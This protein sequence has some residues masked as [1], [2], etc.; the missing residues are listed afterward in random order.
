MRYSPFNYMVF[1]FGALLCAPIIAHAGTWTVNVE[2][3]RIANTDRHYS[4]G[5]RLG[6]VSDAEDGSDIPILRDTLQLLYPLADVR[7]G[8]L[9]LEL[10]HNIYTPSDTE[11]RT[12][13][14]DDR[15]Y[16][17]WLYLSASLNAETGQG[18]GEHYTETLDTMALELGVVGPSALGR[19]VQNGFHKI[20][21]VASNKGWDNQLK[22]EPGINLIGERKWRHRALKLSNFEFDAIPHLGATLGNVYTHANGGATV[23]FGQL[24]D[25]DY[26]PPLIRPNASGFGALNPSDG[27][28]WYLFAGVDGRAVARNTF[29]DGNTFRDSH[30]VDK[31]TLVGDFYTG[32]AIIY[33]SARIAFTHVMRSREFDQQPESD[34]FGAISLSVHF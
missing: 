9:G 10:G 5:F 19:Q 16:A 11:R 18:F 26:G 34:R 1:A 15:P 25:T 27:V 17:G 22:D 8:R 23:R 14:Q 32:I 33:G 21:N 7:N 13:I 3:D 20:I 30:S 29:L 6:W 12:L 24:L 31:K 4:N 28:A 2:N